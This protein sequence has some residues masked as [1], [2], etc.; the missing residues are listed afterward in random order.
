VPAAVHGRVAHRYLVAGAV[1]VQT[2]LVAWAAGARPAAVIAVLA[3]AAAALFAWERRG[4]VPHLD[5][6]VATCA[7]GGLGMALALAWRGPAAHAHHAMDVGALPAPDLRML[8]AMLAVCVPACLWTCAPVC[9]GG[10]ARRALGHLGVT[11][12]M[13]AGMMAG[14]VLAPVFSPVAGAPAGMHLAMVMGMAAGT[15][16][17]LPAVSLLGRA[18]R[19]HHQLPPTRPEAAWQG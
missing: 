15:A 2:L 18:A 3:G 4:R 16:A 9:A 10:W 8:G 5:V 13:V 19:G 6:V 7:F 1:A 11:A 14:A 17:A 12:G